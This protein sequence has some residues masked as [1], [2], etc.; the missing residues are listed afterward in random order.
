MRATPRALPWPE[1][2]AISH[3][4]QIGEF[5]VVCHGSCGFCRKAK[6][7]STA[8]SCQPSGVVGLSGT[9]CVLGRE[10]PRAGVGQH[11]GDVRLLLLVHPADVVF[12]VERLGDVL[13]EERADGHAGHPAH[14]LAEQE[15]LVV[16]VVGRAGAR[17]PQRVL[18]LERRM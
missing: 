16:H 7:R 13:L 8:P 14:D 11:F 18:H 10:Q 15:A 3:V 5:I 1:P 2:L 6:L 4:R 9:A 12:G 17:L